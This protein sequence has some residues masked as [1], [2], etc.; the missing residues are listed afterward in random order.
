MFDL[1]TGFISQSLIRE[2][3]KSSKDVLA[4]EWL[5]QDDSISIFCLQGFHLAENNI[6]SSLRPTDLQRSTPHHPW[7]DIFP[8][9]RTRDNLIRAGDHLDDDELCHD[10]TAFWDTRTS[11]ARLLVGTAV[12]S[13]KLGSHGGICKEVGVLSSRLP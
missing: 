8:L 7:L 5:C 2:F 9:P 11:N 6:P 12:L 10:L 3:Y 1:A 13:G 4:V